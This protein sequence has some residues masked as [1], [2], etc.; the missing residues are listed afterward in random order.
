MKTTLKNNLSNFTLVFLLTIFTFISCSKDEALS[1]PQEQGQIEIEIKQGIDNVD[2]KNQVEKNLSKIK[3]LFQIVPPKS[4]RKS[5][6][7]D[8][9]SDPEFLEDI[10]I[11]TEA[12]GI[13]KN[14]NGKDS[15]TFQVDFPTDSTSVQEIINLHTY[16]DD[17][18]QLKSKLIKYE[19]TN[20][21]FLVATKNQSF[22]GFWDKIS[23]FD[24][25]MTA[26]D[27]TSKKNILARNGDPCT[28]EGSSPPTVV[29]VPYSNNSG[30]GGSSASGVGYPL[31]PLNT[32]PPSVMATLRA[33]G[34]FVGINYNNFAPYGYGH[35]HTI[36][37]RYFSTK[38]LT[39]PSYNPS[40]S[41]T[42]F[43]NYYAYYFSGIKNIITDYYEKVYVPQINSYTNSSL[44]TIEDHIVKQRVVYDFFQFTFELY[45]QNRTSFYY[46]SSNHELTKSIFYFLAE[47][48]TG[49]FYQYNQAKTYAKSAIETIHDSTN[50]IDSLDDYIDSYFELNPEEWIVY[51]ETPGNIIDLNEYLNCFDNA[52]TTATFK[53]TIFVDQPVPNQEDTWT[54][55]GN[56]FNPDINVG[57]TFISLEMNSAGN[58]INQTIGYYPSAGV[59][60]INPEIAGAWVDDG[61]HDYDVSVSTNLTHTQFTSLISNIQ[62]F[63]TPTYNLNTLNCTDAALQIGNSVGINLPDTNGTWIGGG[64]SNPGN[65]GQDIR[66]L[67]S[68]DLTIN[69]TSG[70]ATL[71]EGPCN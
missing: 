41:G 26:I 54:N 10:Q 3:Q 59:D 6:G 32:L 9:K 1:T 56:I 69:T 46:L 18:N 36:P 68:S 48:N 2:L 58:T 5:N 67:S 4:M 47:N 49:S 63:G 29:W 11:I 65:L 53:F 61:N 31:P 30:Y 45:A 22:D 40:S 66:G 7:K 50:D 23:Y 34:V 20:E 27:K 24:L 57:H 52:P 51:D 25:E 44:T 15:Y 21:E 35:Y 43:N 62:T 42:P 8:A 16:Y 12:Y 33:A 38:D 39:I 60:P 28:C 13:I 37:V 19:L 71:S 55:D 17:N 70:T 64:G 14:E